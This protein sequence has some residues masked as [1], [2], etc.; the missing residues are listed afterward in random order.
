MC[1]SKRS[2]RT[3]V[4]M[5]ASAIL[6]VQVASLTANAHADEPAVA[7]DTA[8]LSEARTVKDRNDPYVKGFVDYCK[9]AIAEPQVTVSL[10]AIFPVV[11]T[12][13]TPLREIGRLVR[14]D[15]DVSR[16][17][18][19]GMTQA[20]QAVT[21][22]LDYSYLQDRLTG[23]ICSTMQVHYD[24]GYNAISMH[25]ASELTEGS[26]GYNAVLEHET[27]RV[28]IYRRDLP[29]LRERVLSAVARA[30][31]G[32]YLVSTSLDEAIAKHTAIANSLVRTTIVPAM[33]EIEVDLRNHD[34]GQALASVNAKL[35]ES[36]ELRQPLLRMLSEMERGK[37]I[38]R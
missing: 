20:R 25:L 33:N 19:P 36:G 9:T 7:Q 38:D 30:I 18:T 13:R 29:T 8:L 27:D 26:A 28:S 2:E 35:V 21:P 37:V 10:L 15:G 31:A 17:V 1:S 22:R 3:C 16:V 11:S 23:L 12:L 6:F 4:G 24:V 32:Q 5:F 14:G 34:S